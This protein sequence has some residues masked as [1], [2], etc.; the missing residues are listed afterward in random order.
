MKADILGATWM[1][2]IALLGFWIWR[3]SAGLLAS[4]ESTSALGKGMLAISG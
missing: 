1:F 4:N 2:I 3:T